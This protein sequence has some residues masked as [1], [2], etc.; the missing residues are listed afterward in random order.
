MAVIVR[1]MIIR[2]PFKVRF[3]FWYCGLPDLETPSL[4]FN[5]LSKWQ[6][7]TS[8][9]LSRSLLWLLQFSAP[10]ERPPPPTTPLLPMIRWY[11]NRIEIIWG[12]YFCGT[13]NSSSSSAS[14][15]LALAISDFCRTSSIINTE[16]CIIVISPPPLWHFATTDCYWSGH[17][18]GSRE[19]HVNF[20]QLPCGI[21]DS[22]CFCCCDHVQFANAVSIILIFWPTSLFS[23]RPVHFDAILDKWF[24][25]TI[26]FQNPLGTPNPLIKPKSLHTTEFININTR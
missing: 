19:L 8:C 3:V 20:N 24:D 11:W 23:A 9:R 5:C 4:L 15:S 12:D 22:C 14:S 1:W 16:Q 10:P 7:S 21:S 25:D 17:H 26:S 18:V 6:A 2:F 13:S